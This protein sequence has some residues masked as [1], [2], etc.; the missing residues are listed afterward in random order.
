M[1]NEREGKRM[2]KGIS[3]IVLVITIIV[4]V[5]LS[6][7][8]VLTLNNNGLIAKAEDAV[9]QTN[10]AT[11]REVAQ[12]AWAEAYMGGAREQVDLEQAVLNA[13]AEN[14]ITEKDYKGYTLVVTTKGA[15]LNEIDLM[16]NHRDSIPKGAVYYVGVTSSEYDFGNYTGATAIY[17][18]TQAFPNEV[19][20]GDVYVYGEYE[21]RYVEDVYGCN[22]WKVKVVDNTKTTYGRV[23]ESINNVT[24]V[25]FDEIFGYCE[26][27]TKISEDFVV[28]ES[29]KTMSFAFGACS[30]LKSLPEGFAIPYG[31]V[32]LSAMF[33]SCWMLEALPDSFKVPNTVEYMRCMF[34]E[35]EALT[36]LP[37]DFTIPEKVEDIDDMFEGA[38]LEPGT[39]IIIDAN[40]TSYSVCFFMNDM[41]NITLAG[42]CSRELKQLIANTGEN[43]DQ[44][45]IID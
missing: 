32:D 41:S 39:V 8:I 34:I 33:E 17:K 16:Y 43:A 1:K 38:N 24:I 25:S 40:P 11:I 30:Q 35:D 7:A 28:P 21:Y 42:K 36:H 20:L 31:V 19:K 45:T 10:L 13:L 15:E 27:L 4:M 22:G 14:G 9:K 5:I 2:K 3:L 18:E 29:V 12:M 6:G 26:N 37:K 23:L 44:V